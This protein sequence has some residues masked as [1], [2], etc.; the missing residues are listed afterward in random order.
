MG[1]YSEM[2]LGPQAAPT[3]KETTPKPGKWSKMLL[4]GGLPKPEKQWIEQPDRTPT[5]GISAITGKPITELTGNPAYK[6]ASWK[7]L[8]KAG[9][10]DN[11][12]A[13]FKIFAEAR[14][15]NPSRYEEKNG[16]IWFEG[17]DGNMYPETPKEFDSIIK[18]MVAELPSEGLADIGAG[19]GAASPVPGGAVLG[20]AG[21]EFI[22]K[23]IGGAM[24]DEQTAGDY[25]QDM[26]IQAIFAGLDSGVAKKLM[27]LLNSGKIKKATGGKLT[28]GLTK[29]IGDIS[30]AQRITGR[31]VRKKGEDIGVDV[32]PHQAMDDPTLTGYY[33]MLRDNPKT[34]RQVRMADDKLENQVE[35]AS[36]DLVLDISPNETDAHEVGSRLSAAGDE[37]LNRMRKERS[38]LAAPSYKKAY[39]SGVEVDVQP[40]IDEVVRLKKQTKPGMK[41]H[42]A[43]TKVEKWLFKKGDDGKLVPETDI[44]IL[45]N[46]KI[47]IDQILNA[48]AKDSVQGRMRRKLKQ[49]K[50]QLTT[51][52][53]TVSPDYQKA[54]KIFELA[55]P[56]ITKTENGII[57]ALAGMKTENVKEAA[58]KKIFS[59]PRSIRVAKRH[60]EKADP[61]LWRDAV[62][63]YFRDSFEKSAKVA[64]GSG[65]KVLNRPGKYS[66]KMW[67]LSDQ[68]K[69]KFA[70][71]GMK[72]ANGQPLYERIEDFFEVMQKAS[73]GQGK[74][75]A[76]QPRQKMEK[77][78]Q[79]IAGKAS[80]NLGNLQTAAINMFFQGTK[81]KAFDRN[82]KRLLDLMQTQEGVELIAKAKGYGPG[83]E[84]RIKAATVLLLMATET[85]AEKIKEAVGAIDE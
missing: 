55:S 1:K 8:S 42:S 79:G 64:Q 21:G 5:G 61:E 9:F 19:I 50:D 71:E 75:S 73:I 49:V 35:N 77:E 40:V 39:E 84:Q 83:T 56:E 26:G 65:G 82:A 34:A 46:A 48:P 63:E 43:L 16:K 11:N 17:D 59:S 32:M 36:R 76:T 78:L 22:R 23:Q 13:K 68:R 29:E 24:G 60:I 15:I 74:E 80:A 4:G 57:G 54:R 44:K 53:D 33:S 10:V 20:A 38:D 69:L 31:S 27:S 2:L 18:K 41:A 52:T 30:D 62:A 67:D 81:D 12:E 85:N 7:A 14:G 3:T 51:Q 58:I 37:I 6:P 72:D 66:S 47:E 25:A 28:S 70:T 45:D